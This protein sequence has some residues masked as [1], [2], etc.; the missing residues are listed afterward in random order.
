VPSREISLGSIQ[1]HDEKRVPLRTHDAAVPSTDSRDERFIY[2][3]TVICTASIYNCWA[4]T[5]FGAPE[6]DVRRKSHRNGCD[7]LHPFEHTG[8]RRDARSVDGP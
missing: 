4:L 8:L 5:V 2:I 3:Q 7:K 6:L 1:Y